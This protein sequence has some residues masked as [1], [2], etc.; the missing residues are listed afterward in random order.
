MEEMRFA[1]LVQDIQ[2]DEAA[3]ANDMAIITPADRHYII[4]FTPRSGSSWLTSALS[5]T[6][7]LGFP[8]E[9]INP[10]FLPDVIKAT[11]ARQPKLLIGMLKRRR[12][13]V[14]GIFGMEVRAIDVML[15]GEHDF[16]TELDDTTVFFFLWRDNII[17]Q[18][19]SLY[20]A[21]TTSRY[22]SS[23]R[24]ASPPPVYSQDDIKHWIQH[25]ANIEND[26]LI[27]LERHDRAARFLRY[28]DIVR[29]RATTLSLF[30]EPLR[31]GLEVAELLQPSSEEL[32]KISDSWNC[33][34]EER[35]RREE[36]HYVFGIEER[37]LIRRT[38]ETSCRRDM[39]ALGLAS[40]DN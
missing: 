3:F 18:G 28:E 20:R 33:D 30:A 35:F 15:F 5:A 13:S 6:K 10:A 21:V 24:V 23:D 14:N 12:R 22:H 36:P 8:E 9:Y 25:I 16:F 19:I 7:K 32:T 40:L 38:P 39:P 2:I 29:D 37:R 17:A 34:T 1:N 27:M 26:N 31:V 11:N 4:F